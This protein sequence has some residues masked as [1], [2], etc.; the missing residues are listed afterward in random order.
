MEVWR[1]QGELSRT[2]N[3]VP[4]FKSGYES[5]S[6]WAVFSVKGRT[7][8][9]RMKDDLNQTKYLKILQHELPTFAKNYHNGQRNI[10]F[11]QDGCAPH[12]VTPASPF[13]DAE[14]IELL[15]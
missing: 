11:P 10:I 8:L 6:V 2:V 7:E 15:Q 14:D 3:I 5:I 12:R 13:F 4:T 1:K 9:I